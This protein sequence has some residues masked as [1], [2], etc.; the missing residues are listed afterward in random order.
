MLPRGLMLR[1]GYDTFTVADEN[2]RDRPDLP[3]LLTEHP[4]SITVPGRTRLPESTWVLT[5]ELFP[6][7]KVSDKDLAA[8]RG[9]EAYLDAI[10]VGSSPILRP[11]RPGDRFCPLGMEGRSKRLNEFMIN[12]KIPAAW[13]DRIPLVVNEDGQIVWVCGWRPDERARVTEATQR[14]AW[15][16]FA[17]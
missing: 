7:A 15:L 11:R 8:A 1:I 13:R 3:L 16:R 10:T 14:V 9:W 12:E 2:F 5:V 6:R 17:R 4:V